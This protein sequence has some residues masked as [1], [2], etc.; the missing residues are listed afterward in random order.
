MLTHEEY[1]K[2]VDTT[3]VANSDA[4]RKIEDAKVDT[5]LVELIG[6]AMV[7]KLKGGYY[8]ELLPYVKRCLAYECYLHFV[9]VGNVIVTPV[10]ISERS[11]EFGRKPEFADKKYKID[12]VT[13]VLRGYEKVLIDQI[14]T[15]NYAES[16]TSNLSQSNP[17]NIFAIGD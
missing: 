16:S 7:A 1:K 15:G 11:S 17:F 4:F 10:G 2:I 9:T 5:Y 8:A 6:S 3:D 13:K 14:S 12:A